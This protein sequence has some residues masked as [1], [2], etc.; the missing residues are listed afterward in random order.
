MKIENLKL[1][2]IFFGNSPYSLIG[3]KILHEKLGINLVVTKSDRPDKKGRLVPSHLK[4][5]ATEQNIPCLTLDKLDDQA[6]EQIQAV[7]ADFFVVEDYGLIVPQRFLDLPKYAP[8]NVHH[9]LLPKYRGP[10]PVPFA[11]LAGEQQAGVSI[12]HM[13]NKVDAGDL[14][15]QTQCPV[16][17]IETAD[18]L[19]KKLND[20]GGNLVVEVINDIVAGKAQRQPQNETEATLTHY[21]NKTDGYIDL[22]NPPSPEQIDRMIRAYYPWPTVWTKVRVVSKNDLNISS[23][24]ILKFLPNQTFQLEGKNPVSKKDFL[25]GYP[26]MEKIINQLFTN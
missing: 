9:S 23:E 16:G 12:I 25:N 10:A 14:Y 6:F 20:L 1:K 8:L 19:L 5:F 4:A 2:I 15:A 7:K 3:A 18:S 11:L 22:Q 21:M 13:N 17:K 26:E 24:K